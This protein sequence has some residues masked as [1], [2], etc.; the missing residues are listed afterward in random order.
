[1]ALTLGLW[2]E[3]PSGEEKVD[4]IITMGESIDTLMV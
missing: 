4:V 2:I 1:M 3:R